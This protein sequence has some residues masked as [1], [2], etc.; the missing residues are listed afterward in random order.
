MLYSKPLDV[1]KEFN[2]NS[3]LN[4]YFKQFLLNLNVDQLLTI[5]LSDVK[6]NPISWLNW[7]D[8]VGYL[9]I[10]DDV[11]KFNNYNKNKQVEMTDVLDI[12]IQNLTNQID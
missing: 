1:F 9:S 11:K 5:R 6:D 8:T 12:I 7:W 2:D 10:S 3:N 4:D